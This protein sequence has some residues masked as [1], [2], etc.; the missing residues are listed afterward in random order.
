MLYIKKGKGGALAFQSPL[1]KGDL[2]KTFPRPK[3]ITP[4]EHIWKFFSG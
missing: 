2:W 4:K 1:S 3:F